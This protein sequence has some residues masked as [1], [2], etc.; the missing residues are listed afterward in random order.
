MYRTYINEQEI[1]IKLSTKL[2]RDVHD[3]VP[4]YEAVKS[5]APRVLIHPQQISF[6]VNDANLGLIIGEVQRGAI[7]V[8]AVEHIIQKSHIFGDK[9]VIEEIEREANS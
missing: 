5:V 1:I 3:R 4:V 7:T 8:F 9:Y 6:A 2:Q